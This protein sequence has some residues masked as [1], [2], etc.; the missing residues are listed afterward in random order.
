L[1]NIF[2]G[3][4]WFCSIVSYADDPLSGPDSKIVVEESLQNRLD[5]LSGFLRV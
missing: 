2:K 5:R 3:G 1:L 4:W